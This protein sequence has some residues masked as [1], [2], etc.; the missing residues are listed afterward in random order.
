MSLTLDLSLQ[1][2]GTAQEPEPAV[3]D[4]TKCGQMLPLER[5]SPKKDGRLGRH[6]YCKPCRATAQAP[7]DR[8]RSQDPAVRAA[9]R[10]YERSRR[11][12]PS[13][14]EHVLALGRL[15]N[16]RRR[17]RKAGNLVEAFTPEDLYASWDEAGFHACYW[18]DGDF[19]ESDPMH[20]DHLVP[21]ARG[22]A[23]AIW[24]LVPAHASCNTSKGAK[25]PYAYALERYPWLA[26]S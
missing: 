25:D 5:F 18:C 11:N 20:V 22:G 21:V 2:F 14:R 15:G 23:E 16:Q 9:W 24:N 12:D 19:T 1:P 3:K 6:P 13:T 17:A 8:L 10:E 7:C 26:A 4:C